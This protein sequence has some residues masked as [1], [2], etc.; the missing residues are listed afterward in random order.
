T[1]TPTPTYTPTDTPTPAPCLGA[2]HYLM[3][4]TERD[5]NNGDTVTTGQK[6]T[7]DMMVNTGGFTITA[8]QAY[9]T[10]TYALADN[11]EANSAGC[12]PTSTLTA[13]L[14]ILDA[15]LQ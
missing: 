7:L 2:Y 8:Q 13:D 14:T 10:F 6:F 11:V 9:L 12:V 5:P 4:E 15:L 1:P 3:P